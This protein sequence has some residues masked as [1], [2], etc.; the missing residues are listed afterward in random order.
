MPVRLKLPTTKAKIRERAKAILAASDPGDVI[1][2]LDRAFLR[3]LLDRHPNACEKIGPGV[4]SIRVRAADSPYGPGKCFEVVRKDGTREDFS[5][6]K[7]LGDR[8][9]ER[10]RYEAFRHAVRDQ[11][12][13]ARA[14]AFARPGPRKCPV[15]GESVTPATSHVDHAKPWT[16]K[17]LVETF[18]R[19]R[20]LAVLDVALTGDEVKRIADEKLR[21][22]WCAF[23]RRRAT[24]R[25]V[26]VRANL[27][28]LRRGA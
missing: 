24:L 7:C 22:A 20:S 13:D 12:E 27:S 5:Y 17:R 25:V 9:A 19:K 6:L 11:I 10:D 2:G 28:V 16:F 18:L 26:S 3:A 8:N 15:T 21:A 23:H 14:H 1:R 4:R